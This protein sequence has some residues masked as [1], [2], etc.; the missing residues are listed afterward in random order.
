MV[1][2]QHCET[3]AVMVTH[4]S[5][6][7]SAVVYMHMF[8]SCH[9]SAPGL[10]HDASRFHQ[11]IQEVVTAKRRDQRLW[12]EV[13]GPSGSGVQRYVSERGGW[14]NMCRSNGHG[15]ISRAPLA[16]PFLTSGVSGH[17]RPRCRVTLISVRDCFVVTRC[18]GRNRSHETIGWSHAC[19]L[20]SGC[21]ESDAA[22]LIA[23][24]LES[25]TV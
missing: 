8:V 21:L 13:E 23:G 6:R 9:P 16:S 15:R 3:V 18:D 17:N 7:L 14:S 11:F 5:R 22:V 24:C 12:K 4:V 19:T 10:L 25:C 20:C 1:G 2:E